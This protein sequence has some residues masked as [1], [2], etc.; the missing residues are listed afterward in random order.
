M[1]P[2][3]RLT[4]LGA[5]PIVPAAMRPTALAFLVA[6]FACCAWAQTPT[7]APVG[8]IAEVHG[9]VTM[10]YGSTVATVQA[11]TPVFDGARFVASSSGGAQLKFS[12]GCLVNLAPNQWMSVDSKADCPTRIASVR[13]LS[14]VGGAGEGL[15]ARTALPLAGAAALAGLV[16]RLPDRQITPTPK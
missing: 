6:S 11:D 13:T 8:S 10:S 3:S 4:P 15:F 14:E 5:S 7:P 9:L 1:K 16:A 2:V 12:D